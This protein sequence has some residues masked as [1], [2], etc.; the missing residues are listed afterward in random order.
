MTERGRGKGHVTNMGERNAFERS[1]WGSV[2]GKKK[3]KGLIQD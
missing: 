2:L 1:G 3:L